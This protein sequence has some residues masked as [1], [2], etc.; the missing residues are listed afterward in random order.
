MKNYTIKYKMHSADRVKEVSVLAR[1]KEDA[2]D[3]AFY[4]EIPGIEDGDMAY[5]A[6]VSSVKYQN[7]S[8]RTFNTFEGKSY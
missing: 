7:G 6:W 3:K 8:Y 1:N 4:E 2:Y 5:S